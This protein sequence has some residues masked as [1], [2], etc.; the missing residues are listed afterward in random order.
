MTAPTTPP[1]PRPSGPGGPWPDPIPPRRPASP[2]GPCGWPPSARV[3]TVPV[4]DCCG[5]LPG[6][7]DPCA[8]WAAEVRIA[9]D[10]PVI[11]PPHAPGL[12]PLTDPAVT[13]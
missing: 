2:V 5:A 8:D 12:A 1:D 9:F 11:L 7:E 4:S 13:P 10:A 6:D 3:I